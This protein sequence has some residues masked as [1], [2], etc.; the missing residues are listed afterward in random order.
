VDGAG[1]V[2]LATG[3]RARA[4]AGVGQRDALIGHMGECEGKVD[5]DRLFRLVAQPGH[6]DD[7]S[8]GE[9]ILDR[10]LGRRSRRARRT[11]LTNGTGAEIRGRWG[12]GWGK[13]GRGGNRQ[14]RAPL[15]V[16]DAYTTDLRNNRDLC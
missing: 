1:D 6:M 4:I 16:V 9:E 8:Q 15:W 7:G 10:E 2:A 14:N 3:G 11:V 13:R 5:R 12:G